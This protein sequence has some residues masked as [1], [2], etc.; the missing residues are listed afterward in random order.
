MKV[1]YICGA[2]S[3][4]TAWLVEQNVRRAEEHAL[5]V[6]ELG[7]APLC[8]HTNTRSFHGTITPEFWYNATLELLRRCDVLILAPGWE[9]SIVG[10]LVELRE[11]RKLEIPVFDD[12]AELAV[13]LKAESKRPSKLRRML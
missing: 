9:T 6:A 5:K 4:P 3:A 7:A 11:A 1:V 8:P 10:V 2:F 12:L 13:W